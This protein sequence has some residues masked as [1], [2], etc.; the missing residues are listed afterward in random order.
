M[1]IEREI[2]GAVSFGV[3]KSL[4]TVVKLKL[5]WKRSRGS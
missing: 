1:D 4:G 3:G 5:N 2:V